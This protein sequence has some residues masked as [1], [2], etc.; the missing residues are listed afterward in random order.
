MF[1]PI[2]IDCGM[3]DFFRNNNLRNSSLPFDW[4]VAYNGIS[5]CIDDNFKDFIPNENER[6]NKYDIY[7]H[8]DFTLETRLDDIVK[9]NRRIERFINI[10]KNTEEKIVFCR[11]GHAFHNHN[12]HNGK[13]EFI[14][15]DIDDAEELDRVLSEKYPNLKYKIIVIIVCGKCFDSKATY[16]SNSN[17][18]EIYNIATEHV[19]NPL[20]EKTVKEIFI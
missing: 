5:K 3:A 13:Y 6:I 10:L 8:H 18:L 20:F 7:F 14:K 1:I 2:G 12:E 15:S 9:Y 17:N 11:K 16:K 19:D 4:N